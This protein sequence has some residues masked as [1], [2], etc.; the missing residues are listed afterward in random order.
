MPTAHDNAALPAVAV[1]TAMARA[2]R[3]VGAGITGSAWNTIALAGEAFDTAAFHDT[4][5]N[6]SRLTIPSDG[7]YRVD[8]GISFSGGAG[9]FRLA[10]IFTGGVGA[11]TRLA[12]AEVSPVSGEATKLSITTWI[13]YFAAGAYV[14]LGAYADATGVSVD[15]GSGAIEDTWLTIQRIT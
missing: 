5:T 8:G 6:N 14:E 12:S 3:D 4:V 7:Y 2:Y 1:S 9:T 13:R 10:V 11:G 15:G